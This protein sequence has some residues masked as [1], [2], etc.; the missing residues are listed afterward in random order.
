MS[1]VSSD[2]NLID[3][4]TQDSEHLYFANEQTGV[5]RKQIAKFGNSYNSNKFQ[6]E[7]DVQMLQK[8]LKEEIELRVILENAMEHAAVELLDL[9]CIPNDAHELLSNIATLEDAIVKLEAESVSLHFQLIQER[10]ERR[11][12]EYRMKQLPS[13]PQVICSQSNDTLYEMLM[14]E[15]SSSPEVSNHASVGR[16]KRHIP[17]KGLSNYPNQLSEE[18]VR[19]MKNIFISLSDASVVPSK[20]SSESNYPSTSPCGHLSSSSRWSLSEMSMMSSWSQSPQVDLQSASEI[21]AAES[22]CDP[23]KVRGKLCWNDIGN[24]SFAKEVSWM[25][26]DKKQLD[27]AADALRRFRSLIEQLA[28]VNPIHMNDNEKLAFWINLYNALIMHAYLAYGV[29]KSDMKLFSLMQKAAYTVGGHS[30]SA[31]C[32][33]YAILKVKPPVHRPQ[34]ALLLAL[35]KSKVTEEQKKFAIEKAEPLVMF[36]LSCGAY[37]SPAVKVYTS[38]NVKDELQESQRDFI[39]A[40]VGLSMKGKLLVP[41]MLHSFARGFVEDSKL[42]TWISRFLP[43]EQAAFVEQC[44]SQR[45]SFI[46][47]KNCGVLAFDSRFRYLFLPETLH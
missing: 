32:I 11:L 10:N 8:R 25:S 2:R 46:S 42:A 41:K 4:R 7:Q 33:E 34:T 40:S 17:V 1:V 9:S 21:L 14:E 20:A 19:C 24:Y 35:Q 23:Y 16:L 6:L 38:K 44:V 18:I 39:R 3:G 37:S 45:R 22:S 12:D 29:P 43:Q 30:F 31:T 5:G 47:S 36:A 26:V 13:R 28:E 27:Y 15:D